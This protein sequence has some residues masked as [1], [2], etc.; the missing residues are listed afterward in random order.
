MPG[1]SWHWYVIGTIS[2][3]LVPQIVGNLATGNTIYGEQFG[4]DAE[5]NGCRP[6]F[7]EI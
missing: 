5:D 3:R 4:Y 7:A 6:T 1:Y 2:I